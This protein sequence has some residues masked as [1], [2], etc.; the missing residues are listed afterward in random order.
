MVY[1]AQHSPHIHS[2]PMSVGIRQTGA[3]RKAP[4]GKETENGK[5]SLWHRHGVVDIMRC[6]HICEKAKLRLSMLSISQ[7]SAIS[8]IR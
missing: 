7:I 6:S 3:E 8:P 2:Y 4:P 1:E 5:E